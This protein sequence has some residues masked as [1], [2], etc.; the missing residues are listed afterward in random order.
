M[1][2]IKF[3]KT[4]KYNAFSKQKAKF[5]MTENNRNYIFKIAL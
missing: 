5:A 1:F 2:E 4:E 3:T